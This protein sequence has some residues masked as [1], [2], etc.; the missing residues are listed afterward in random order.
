M[1]GE[2]EQLI[3]QETA[4]AEANDA[5][6]E[7]GLSRRGFLSRGAGAAAAL[8]LG[9]PAMAVAQGHD[10]Q[11]PPEPPKSAEEQARIAK[12]EAAY[13][14]RFAEPALVTG[15]DG[16]VDVTLRVVEVPVTIREATQ[17]RTELARTYNGQV[18][19]PTI[20][21]YPGDYLKLHLYNDLPKNTD[22]ACMGGHPMNTPHCFNTTNLHTHGLHVSPK[23]PSD[24]VFLEIPPLAEDPVRGKFDFCFALPVS[25]K[26]GTHW[27]HAH[28]HGSTAIQLVNGMAGALIVKDLPGQEPMAGIKDVV[29]VIHETVGNAAVDVY[30]CQNGCGTKSSYLVNGLYKPTIN[31]RPG[32][33]QRWRFINATA[34]PRGITNLTFTTAQQLIAVDGIYLPTP[35]K[36][37]NF[38]LAPG[39][40][41][42]YLV[43]FNTAGTTTVTKASIPFPGCTIPEQ[44]LMNVNVAGPA[45]S[46]TLPTENPPL[47]TYLQKTLSAAS[48]QPEAVSVTP[49]QTVVFSVAN[50]QDCA[51]KFLINGQPFGPT[52]PPITVPLGA[53]QIWEVQNS[54]NAPHPFHIHVNPFVVIEKN[55]T[56]VP[57]EQQFFQDTVLIRP[58]QNGVNGSV[59][60]I[61]AFDN[62]D[63]EFVIHCHIL[64]HEDWGMMRKVV[65]QGPG[66]GPCVRI[67]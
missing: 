64:I 41:Q 7:S 37:T 18:P 38:P 33:I 66:V 1:S 30:Q 65:V 32:E 15:V 36:V 52:A 28:K 62:F 11:E 4:Q 56:A 53:T 2:E 43:Q 60:F 61:T 25:H 17:T 34:T 49:D 47:P 10:H 51:G 59:K 44:V 50:Q 35:R 20:S 8:I 26:P 42:D 21:V 58:Q 55:G 39:N 14:E 67:P 13:Y 29:F 40:R 23:V 19:G 5:T 31:I 27:Y 45:M 9:G 24:N 22:P 12:A 57:P 16:V 63:G 6:P 54:S 46:M 48:V 3:P